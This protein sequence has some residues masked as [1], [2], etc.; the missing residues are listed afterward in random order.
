MRLSQLRP[1]VAA[2]IASALFAAPAAAALAPAD[3]FVAA[4]LPAA[5]RASTVV[6]V[7]DFDVTGIFSVDPFGDPLNEVF[8]IP[9]APNASVI[10][11][12]WDVTFFA[13]APSWLSEAVV[14]FGSSST[15]V[16]VTLT[17]GVGDDFPGTS[18][19]SSGGIISL[20]PGLDFAVDGDGILRLEFFESFDDFPDDWDG[21]WQSGTLSIQWSVP[22]GVIPEPATWAMMI[23]GFGLV[24]MM[25]RRRR[26]TAT[27]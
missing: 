17:V 22:G 23:A 8:N 26:G 2:A 16:F 11:I 27:A 9:L 4:N 13:D 1:G 20:V 18:T 6:T 21:I 25:A 19:Y 3:G 24:G 15:P 12:G 5:E 14:A 7:T 10:G